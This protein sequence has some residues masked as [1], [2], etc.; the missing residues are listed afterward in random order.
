MDGHKFKINK[1]VKNVKIMDYVNNI[2]K[3]HVNVANVSHNTIFFKI[4]A[5]KPV[6]AILI[7]SMVNV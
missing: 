7:L 4:N 2:I 6:L 3:T 1:N 5:F